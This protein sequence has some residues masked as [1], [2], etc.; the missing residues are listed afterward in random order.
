M[1]SKQTSVIQRRASFSEP[2]IKSD[3][4]IQAI[5]GLYQ[6]SLGFMWIGTQRGLV[7]LA[8]M[9]AR[10]FTNDPD[11][12]TS[13]P[14]KFII[15]IGEDQSGM[16]WF[17]TYDNGL[18]CYD[19]RLEQFSRPSI[20][21]VSSSDHIVRSFVSTPDGRFWIGSN[22]SLTAYDVERGRY[23]KYTHPSIDDLRPERNN[24]FRALHVLDERT[25]IVGTAA[26]VFLLDIYTESF[27]HLP[28]D[29]RDLLGP[30]RPGVIDIASTGEEIIVASSSQIYKLDD[31]REK[32]DLIEP[33]VN[34]PE[35]M[36]NF[37]ITSVSPDSDPTRLWIGTTDGLLRLESESN[38]YSRFIPD[39]VDSRSLVGGSVQTLLRDRSGML[40]IGMGRGISLLDLRYNFDYHYIL[41]EAGRATVTSAIYQ[42]ENKK[43]WLG[44]PD[45]LWEYN[46]E[47]RK[48][49]QFSLG[50]STEQQVRDN[51]TVRQIVPGKKSLWIGTANGLLEWDA[52]SQTVLN[53]YEAPINTLK[54][55]SEKDILGGQIKGVIEDYQG[56]VWSGSDTLGMQRLNPKEGRF[57]HYLKGKLDQGGL[58]HETMLASLE[59]QNG[60]LWFGFVT[61]LA[62]YNREEDTFENYV[63]DAEEPQSL[64]N[65]M[66]MALHQ[67]TNGTIWVG[68][69]GGLNKV[70]VGDDEKISFVRYGRK[71]GLP[72]DFIVS[73]ESSDD[74][75]WLG[76]DRGLVRVREEGNTIDAR[77]FDGSD[78]VHNPGFH[79]GASFRNH[80]NCLCFGSNFGFDR[81]NPKHLIPDTTPPPVVLT[82]LR[83]SNRHVPIGRE[84]QRDRSIESA[85]TFLSELHLSWYDSAVT[86]EFAALHYL[87]AERIGYAYQLEGFD[88]GWVDAGT[89]TEA[90]YTNLNP[91]QYRFK[92]KARNADG[93]WSIEPATIVVDIEAPPWRRWWAYMLY[94]V[95]G[96]GAITAFTRMQIEARERELR[97]EQRIER[98]REE[99]RES[100][101]RQNAADFHD[102]AGTTLTRILFMTEL[103]RRQA[104]DHV[105]LRELLEKIDQNATLLSQGMRDFIWVLDPDQDTLL[106]TLQRVSTVGEALFTHVDTTFTMRYDHESLSDIALDL[107]QR[108]QTLMICKEALHNAVR[109][110]NA[111]SVIV[112]AKLREAR[113]TLCIADNGHGFDQRTEASGYG[114]K[115]MRKRAESL[116]ATLSVE[117]QI[118][119]GTTVRLEML[120]AR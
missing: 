120:L 42:D 94:G 22:G 73:I 68:T 45:G 81:F 54:G 28:F 44:T 6:D 1:T 18:V 35:D 69:A 102:E 57:R 21:P 40:W 33:L 49:K 62:R 63:H 25:L 71:Q 43:Y 9:E 61:C 82:Q 38:S 3:V 90:T 11:D 46:L 37:T 72:S 12:P 51:N 119:Q 32:L 50:G 56:Y 101:R 48:A 104:E 117:S 93:L 2:S 29:E 110:S 75:L 83:L 77:L 113:L 31:R 84:Q 79:L 36:T 78:G 100:I 8:G 55:R 10:H 14:G 15:A 87:Q 24:H 26:G 58:P 114:M 67:D 89:K 105:E 59:D 20:E 17:G 64:G 112:K 98:A 92:V 118:G 47:E 108:R 60:L 80:D 70:I 41:D 74:E 116:G 13:I 85:I 99:E 111:S 95:A 91:G 96:A 103:A 106:D 4:P 76:T 19:P 115:S 97:E 66:V 109:H 107:H 53:R 27:T 39:E 65:N 86:F 88:Q 5:Y 52:E 23:Q 16:L 7:R 30:R 34:Q